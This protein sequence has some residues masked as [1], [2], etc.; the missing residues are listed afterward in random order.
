MKGDCVP[1]DF[2]KDLQMKE[3]LGKKCK[4]RQDKH[5]YI[6]LKKPQNNR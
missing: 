5:N 2:D 1:K 6:R 3:R 4:T